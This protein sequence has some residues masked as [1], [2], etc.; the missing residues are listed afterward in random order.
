MEVHKIEKDKKV[1]FYMCHFCKKPKNNE[2]IIKCTI[3]DCN[4]TFCNNCID[5]YFSGFADFKNLQNESNENGWVCFKC[6]NL[7]NCLICNNLKKK[8]KSVQK[9]QNINFHD[10]NPYLNEAIKINEI[11][12]NKK[13]NDLNENYLF[14]YE[15]EKNIFDFLNDKNINDK[16]KENPNSEINDNKLKLKKQGEKKINKKNKLITI[17]NNSGLINVLNKENNPNY[18]KK[19]LKCPFT[20]TKNKRIKRLKKKLFK[21]AHLCEHYYKN[22]C[23]CRYFKKNCVICK[24]EEHHINELL[25]FKNS[26]DFINYLRYLFLCMNDIVNY[27]QENFE[28]NKKDLLEFFANCENGNILW[29]FN[30]TTILC[31]YCIYEIINKKNSLNIFKN[32]LS[33]KKKDNDIEIIINCDNQSNNKNKEDNK[34]FIIPEY[35]PQKYLIYLYNILN[36]IL[37][38]IFKCV[39]I[40]NSFNREMHR[41]IYDYSKQKYSILYYNLVQLKIDIENDL[42]KYIE[43]Q[44]DYQHKI[45]E[46][47]GVYHFHI[48]NKNQHQDY[49]TSIF[50]IKIENKETSERIEQLIQKFLLFNFDFLNKIFMNN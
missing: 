35:I 13:N 34:N 28:E 6:E 44:K 26:K 49:L 3:D 38:K 2:E 48:P 15:N 22:K 4:E 25:R 10:T 24:K 20:K 14:N 1:Y 11:Q 18:N 5:K 42:K 33:E 40:I 16:K 50:F 37:Q 29:S 32:F 43:F 7:C 19:D 46:F 23:K 31:K 17:N 30:T 39:N 9:E 21:V 8:E 36:V 41:N 45:N 47:V 27:C 12:N